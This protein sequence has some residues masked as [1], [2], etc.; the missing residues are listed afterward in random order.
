[1]NVQVIPVF[2]CLSVVGA[3]G[4]GNYREQTTF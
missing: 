4:D 2:F 1:M 3:N